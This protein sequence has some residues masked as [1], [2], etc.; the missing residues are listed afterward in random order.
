MIKV[1]V[2]SKNVF[3]LVARQYSV[4]RASLETELTLL[5]CPQFLGDLSEEDPPVPI[6]N[7]EVKL[8]SADGT[9]ALAVGE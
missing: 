2:S 5:D 9:A 6:P 3:I 8:F 4:Q 1:D 7:T